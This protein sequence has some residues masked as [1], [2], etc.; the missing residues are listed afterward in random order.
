MLGLPAADLG[1]GRHDLPQIEDAADQVVLGD[2][3]NDIS[4]LELARQRDVKWD[5]AW[6]MKKKLMEVMR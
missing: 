3:K 6:L 5:T 4:G 2:A 1:Q